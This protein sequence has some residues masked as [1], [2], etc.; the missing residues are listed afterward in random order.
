MH[1]RHSPR[2]PVCTLPPVHRF[3]GELIRTCRDATK[4]F[5]LESDRGR[6]ESS[7][8]PPCETTLLTACVPGRNYSTRS[9]YRS[10]IRRLSA[11]TEGVEC[12]G[13]GRRRSRELRGVRHGRDFGPRDFSRSSL[14]F[15][16]QRAVTNR[17]GRERGGIHPS[18]VPR[19]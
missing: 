18:P 13:A 5:D 6:L 15:S 11:G 12:G 10:I 8:I 4:L 14:K 9:R 1:R 16:S 3:V 7:P 19:Q 17:R 2:F